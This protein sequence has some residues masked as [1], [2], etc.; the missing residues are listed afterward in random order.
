MTIGNA[1]LST[2]ED[3]IIDV[4]LAEPRAS[5]RQLATDAGV[6]EAT[7]RAHVMRMVTD[8]TLDIR[9]HAHPLA[10]PTEI[11]FAATLVYDSVDVIDIDHPAL[12]SALWIA[13]NALSPVL[14][15]EM[16]ASSTEQVGLLMDE[17]SDLPGVDRAFATI[18]YRVHSGAGADERQV[19]S[20]GRWGTVSNIKLDALD[21][22]ILT[23]LGNDG[24]AS[25]TDVGR[26]VGLS[27]QAA[28]RRILSM[29]RD[30]VLRFSTYVRSDRRE[31]HHAILH[32]AVR[33]GHRREFLDLIS[34]TGGV[35]SVAEVT[36]E[37]PFFAE[38]RT[39]SAEDLAQLVRRLKAMEGIVDPQIEPILVI[40]DLRVW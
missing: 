25:Y 24:R 11:L 8:G 15:A 37:R 12:S 26:H 9:G 38:L 34:A 3:R 6:N 36:S 10:Q 31:F 1:S 5:F 14:F 27:V 2:V 18:A 7:A 35:M 22:Q 28:R 23:I 19:A 21:R 20:A 29:A 39:Q 4:L 40:R 17:V 13:R 33:S 16:R 30:G 32:C